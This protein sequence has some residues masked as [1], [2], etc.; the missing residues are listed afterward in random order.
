MPTSYKHR[1]QFSNTK[2]NSRMDDRFENETIKGYMSQF[3]I[4]T[5]VREF[6]CLWLAKFE[7]YGKFESESKRTCQLLLPAY[8]VRK[9]LTPRS[10]L[11]GLYESFK[12]TELSN[13]RLLRT[14]KVNRKSGRKLV[15]P[16]SIAQGKSCLTYFYN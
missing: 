15:I 14:C 8:C 1:G 3:S 7:I 16:T 13:R 12:N 11:I 10:L 9:T 4:P 6:L 5:L 2:T